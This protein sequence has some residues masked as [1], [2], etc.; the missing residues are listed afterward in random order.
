MRN[1]KIVFIVLKNVLFLSCVAVL[2]LL[3]IRSVFHLEQN[4][5]IAIFV[6]LLIPIYLLASYLTEDEIAQRS[7]IY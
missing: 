5:I 2:S 1:L 3:V 6:S 7:D 4:M